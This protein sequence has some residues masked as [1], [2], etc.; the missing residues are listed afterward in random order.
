MV[1]GIIKPQGISS[2]D[3][4]SQVRRVFGERRVGHAGTLDPFATGVLPILVGPATRLDKYL[5][6][7]DKEYVADI[8]FGASTTTDDRCGEVLRT[9][10]LD[11]MLLDVTF[12]EKMLGSFLGKSMQM[13]PAY[14]AIKVNGKKACDEARRGNVITLKPRPIEVHCA[15]LLDIFEADG[16]I[17]WKVAFHVSKG[18]YIRALA[19][20]IGSKAGVPAHLSEL[21]R[22]KV[23]CI[24]EDD[25][26]PLE[27]LDSARLDAMVD[28]VRMLGM[29][30]AFMPDSVASDI[31]NGRSIPMSRARL[32]ECVQTDGIGGCSCIPTFREARSPMEEGELASVVCVNKLV[33]ICRFSASDGLLKPDCV[34]QIGVCRGADI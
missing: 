29:K 6:G 14:S 24:G 13:P 32:C 31:R 34:F 17:H 11:P 28:P 5:S 16:A 4:V 20:D 27:M 30:V 33:S 18:T 12:A 22:C 1:L 8:A 19:R 2:H 7:H 25:C 3:V 26:T 9:G 21:E 10:S 15:R 23:G